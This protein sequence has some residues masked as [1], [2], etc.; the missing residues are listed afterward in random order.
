MQIII[1][2]YRR[3]ARLIEK[4]GTIRDIDEAYLARTTLFVRKEEAMDYHN[5]FSSN[6]DLLNRGVNI[7]SFTPNNPKFGWGDTMDEIIAYAIA[8]GLEKILIMDDDLKMSK[9]YFDMEFHD[10]T[11]PIYKDFAPHPGLF[12]EMM[13]DLETVNYEIPIMGIIARQFS[14]SKIETY[15]DNGRLMQLFALHIPFFKENNFRFRMDDGPFYMSDVW[16]CLKTLQAGVRNRAFQRYV[17]DDKPNAPGGCMALGRNPEEHREC[18]M[19][20]AKTF[21]HLVQITGTKE[22]ATNWGA[23]YLQTQIKWS[24]AFVERQE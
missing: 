24:K 11:K 3:S 6:T 10:G 7:K 16:F 4:H 8:E 20:I 17:R 14:M 5:S 1:P 15:K 23:G 13:K 12:T 19:K 21:P 9:M 18:V 22:N 2:S